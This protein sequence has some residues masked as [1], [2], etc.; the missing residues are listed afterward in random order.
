MSKTLL[1]TLG[2]IFLLVSICVLGCNKSV[3]KPVRVF[4]GLNIG[5][6]QN[7]KLSNGDMVKIS[8]L[9][10]KEVR[11]S[12][13]NAI[14]A[15]FVKVNVDGEEIVLSTGNYN[16]PVVV[17]KVQIDCP[18]LKDYFTGSTSGNKFEWDALFR[19]W[20]K[21]SPFINPGTFVYPIKQKW[22][23][24]MTQSGH[25][26]TYVDWGENPSNKRIYYHAGHDIGGAEGM[27]EIVSATDGLIVSA[28]NEILKGYDSIPV[29]SHFDA[30]N[31]LDDRGWILQYVHLDSTDTGIKLGERI[32][33]GQK[34]GLIGKQGSSGGWVHLHFEIITKDIPS[35][36]WLTED[37]YVY[38]WE[39]Y[40]S[41][42]K[43]QLIAVARPHQLVWAGQEVTI[44]G[45][46]SKSFAGNIIS[47]NWTFTDG[48]TADGA[49]RKRIYEKPGEYSEILKVTD[50]KGNIDYDFAV[51]QVCDRQNPEKKFP[52]IQPAYH[53]TLNIKPG[54]PVT[55]LVRT[56]NSNVSNEVWNFGDGS[57]QVTV[58]SETVSLKDN[59]KGKF[60][61]TV[62]SFSKSGHYIVSV[63]RSN[64]Y[65]YNAIAH[66]HVTVK[67]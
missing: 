53:P 50:S 6:S 31:V 18:V 51:V 42:Y 9:E 23:A 16:L 15:A 57:P 40:I 11:D 32:K 44:D 28:R 10:I 61:E 27:D 60:A 59:T 21:N 26:P 37:A 49:V 14:R 65:G 63:E 13:R 30:V 5:Q 3:L 64:E 8:L 54:D 34:V 38:A 22:F 20:P 4:A 41:Q 19:L 39:S 62:H 52:T 66:L 47:Y 46:K 36:K 43:P 48:T 56:F 2:I 45:S 12:L 7:V 25:E 1:K 24:N 33:I 67:D 35:G 17:G 55:F 58:K 29:Y